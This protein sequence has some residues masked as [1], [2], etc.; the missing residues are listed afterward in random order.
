MDAQI[1]TNAL[2]DEVADLGGERHGW[3]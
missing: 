1:A 2:L 3:A